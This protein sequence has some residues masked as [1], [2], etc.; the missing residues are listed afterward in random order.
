[1][2]VKHVAV[3]ARQL[4]RVVRVVEPLLRVQDGFEATVAL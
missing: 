4:V 3:R 1:M 2:R